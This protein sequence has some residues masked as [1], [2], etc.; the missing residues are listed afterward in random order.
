MNST[1]L[2]AVSSLY[3]AK[4][5]SKYFLIS[6]RFPDLLRL[7]AATTHVDLGLTAAPPL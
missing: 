1:A 5:P 2:F 6:N 3:E 4:K 7:L